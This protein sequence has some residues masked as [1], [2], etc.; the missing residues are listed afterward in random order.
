MLTVSDNCPGLSRRDF[1]TVGTLGLGG[2]S[3]PSLLAAG[4]ERPSHITGKSVIFLFQQGGPSQFET[5]DPKPEAPDG[6]RTVTGTTKTFGARYHL[7]RHHES[8][9]QAGAQVHRR[10]L[11]SDQ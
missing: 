8:T 10:S 9:G 5:F 7:R 2:L 11:L 3:L 1:L 4:G 6:I